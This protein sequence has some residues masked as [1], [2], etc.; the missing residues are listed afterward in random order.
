MV[1]I[2]KCTI[3]Y[4]REESQKEDGQ[5]RRMETLTTSVATAIIILIIL[6]KVSVELHRDPGTQKRQLIY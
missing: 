6:F 3:G 5:L 1:N 2:D 4:Y